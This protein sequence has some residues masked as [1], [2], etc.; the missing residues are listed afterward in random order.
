MAAALLAAL[1]VGCQLELRRRRP[2]RSA[3]LLKTLS[4]YLENC[5]GSRSMVDG[6]YTRTEYRKDG[7]TAGTYD[8]YFFTPS[9]KRFRSRAEI[10]RYFH[11]EVRCGRPIRHRPR[12]CLPAA[13]CCTADTSWQRSGR[14]PSC[15]V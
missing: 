10:A 6:W 2:Q 13:V 12:R 8:T 1:P 4:E 9:G 3:H 15:G 11:L 14:I 7:A 5:G